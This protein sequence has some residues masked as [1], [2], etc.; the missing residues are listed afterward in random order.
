MLGIVRVLECLEIASQPQRALWT[1]SQVMRFSMCLGAEP[2]ER[3]CLLDRL[4]SGVVMVTGCLQK[5]AKK[6]YHYQ[7]RLRL[8]QQ[9]L[10]SHQRQSLACP[11]QLHQPQLQRQ[12]LRPLVAE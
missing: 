6:N 4:S 11:Y 12:E 7:Q 2:Y 1:R 5:H 3:W 9:L 10:F 8:R